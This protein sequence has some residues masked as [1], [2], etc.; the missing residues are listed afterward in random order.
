MPRFFF[1]F[2]SKDTKL[3]DGTSVEMVDLS[4]AYNRALRLVYSTLN[5]LE[6]PSERWMVR[7]RDERRSDTSNSVN[8]RQT[9]AYYSSSSSTRHFVVRE[10][11]GNAAELGKVG[12]RRGMQG[13]EK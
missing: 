12:D 10:E 3:S 4:A 9:A 11:S 5:Y 7:V 6:E 2:I 13:E 1:D 8:C